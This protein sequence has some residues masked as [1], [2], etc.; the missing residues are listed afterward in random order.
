MIFRQDKSI[1]EFGRK[2]GYL[3]SYLIFTTMVYFLLNILNKL[4]N[5]WSYFH[6]M[7]LTFCIILVGETIRRLLR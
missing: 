1:K 2:T 6:V 4:P 7:F 3:F 5:S